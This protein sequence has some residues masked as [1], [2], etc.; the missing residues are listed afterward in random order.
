MSKSDR[1]LRCVALVADS[2]DPWAVFRAYLDG[3]SQEAA[4]NVAQAVARP[5]RRSRCLHRHE[6]VGAR[7]V[8]AHRRRRAGP[9]RHPRSMHG[10]RELS[11]SGPG[12]TKEPTLVSPWSSSRSSRTSGERSRHSESRSPPRPSW[13]HSADTLL[14]IAARSEPEARYQQARHDVGR[15][16]LLG[17][18]VLV[19]GDI[20]RTVGVHP[21]P[22]SVAVLAPLLIRTLLTITIRTEIAHESTGT[23]GQVLDRDIS[24]ASGPSS[25]STRRRR[26]STDPAERLRSLGTPNGIRTRAATLRGWCPRPLDDGGW[27][28][29]ERTLA[30][31]PP[32]THLRC[33]PLRAT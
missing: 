14:S 8:P 32:R 33:Q 12:L 20:I 29:G 9:V 6:R 27:W 5:T 2:S 23:G 13:P 16:V 25:V 18:E 22:T 19:A 24:L 4:A 1:Q 10:F 28:C 11:D 7:R 17:L 15:G 30:A 3:S 26:T 31:D 21:T